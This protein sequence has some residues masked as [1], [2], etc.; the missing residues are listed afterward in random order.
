MDQEGK[1]ND[2]KKTKWGGDISVEKF[3][4]KLAKNEVDIEFLN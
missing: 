3:E 2:E 4:K 1:I